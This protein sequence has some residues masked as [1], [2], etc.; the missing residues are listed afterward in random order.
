[1]SEILAK[2]LAEADFFRIRPDR[3]PW[4]ALDFGESSLRSPVFSLTGR[5]WVTILLNPF[6]ALVASKPLIP[7]RGGSRYLQKV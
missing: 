6:E 4:N 5:E 1:M 7:G 3:R 2:T